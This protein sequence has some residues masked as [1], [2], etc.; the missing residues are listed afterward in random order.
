MAS[1]FESGFRTR[2]ASTLERPSVW[3]SVL[4]TSPRPHHTILNNFRSSLTPDNS[5]ACLPHRQDRAS[6]SFMG[7]H[8]LQPSIG[9]GPFR[10]A[11]AVRPIHLHQSPCLQVQEPC[12]GSSR[13]LARCADPLHG[14]TSAAL[15]QGLDLA[16]FIHALL[17]LSPAPSPSLSPSPSPSLSTGLCFF[18]LSTT[19]SGT[20]WHLFHASSPGH[21][22]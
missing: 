13:S 12:R 17:P 3:N 6:S 20:V 21:Q 2:E 4:K 7:H 14:S 11:S 22:S 9:G 8:H 10:V 19:L 16:G 1:T 18:P 5:C 15:S